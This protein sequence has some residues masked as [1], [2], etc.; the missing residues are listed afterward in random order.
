MRLGTRLD[1]VGSSPRVSGACQDGARE[2]TGR[3]RSLV[4][5]L[6]GVAERLAGSREVIANLSPEMVE[7]LCVGVDGIMVVR[8]IVPLTKG[9]IFLHSKRGDVHVSLSPI[10]DPSLTSILPLEGLDLLAVT[11]RGSEVFIREFFNNHD[12]LLGEVMEVVRDIGV[13]HQKPRRVQR[14]VAL[15]EKLIPGDKD[16]GME[17]HSREKA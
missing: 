7:A 2:F 6:S 11:G 8:A 9:G 4:K 15:Q 10:N 16:V 17:C 14:D 12:P 5:R 1:I 3:R 13:P